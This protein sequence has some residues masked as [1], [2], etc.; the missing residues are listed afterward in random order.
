MDVVE[1]PSYSRLATSAGLQEQKEPKAPVHTPYGY[2]SL[3]FDACS[4]TGA[5]DW[6]FLDT[7]R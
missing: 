3:G 1:H 7:L 4:G 6:R 2:D 5:D